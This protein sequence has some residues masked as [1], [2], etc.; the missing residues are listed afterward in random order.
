MAALRNKRE[1]TVKLTYQ[2]YSIYRCTKSSRGLLTKFTSPPKLCRTREL[3]AIGG[4]VDEL[5]EEANTQPSFTHFH[6][7]TFNNILFPLQYKA[8]YE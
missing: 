3:F 4:V 6:L 8:S 7:R 1:A 2:R 5:P